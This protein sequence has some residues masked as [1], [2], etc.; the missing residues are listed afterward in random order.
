MNEGLSFGWR[1]IED[2][3]IDDENKANIRQDLHE[4]EGTLSKQEQDVNDQQ[5][6]Y[7]EWF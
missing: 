2:D 4:V 5:R 1:L 3:S 7:T 6:R